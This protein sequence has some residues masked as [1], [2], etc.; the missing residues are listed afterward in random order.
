MGQSVGRP[1]QW[2]SRVIF[3]FKYKMQSSWVRPATNKQIN[4]KISVLTDFL[5]AATPEEFWF[6]KRFKSSDRKSTIDWCWG[7]IAAMS[8][9]GTKDETTI[10]GRNFHRDVCDVQTQIMRVSWWDWWWS[11]GIKIK[12]WAV[13]GYNPHCYLSTSTLFYIFLLIY[14]ATC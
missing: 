4:T 6:N 7:E 3:Q 14:G 9:E 10:G 2:W 12:Q 8:A 5:I 13:W 1:L 11:R